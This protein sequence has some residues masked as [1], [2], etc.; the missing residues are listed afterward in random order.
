MKTN[1]HVLGDLQGATVRN[2][3]L[4]F[5]QTN[6]EDLFGDTG[7]IR[8][9]SEPVP[10]RQLSEEVALHPQP[11]ATFDND[12]QVT[13]AI[14]G[15]AEAL[16]CSSR[17]TSIPQQTTD[18]RKS[19]IVEGHHCRFCPNC[20]LEVKPSHN[21]CPNCRYRLQL[22]AK[23]ASDL[24]GWRDTT[25]VH[26]ANPQASADTSATSFLAH[27]GRLRYLEASPADVQ[28]AR[29]L[30]QRVLAIGS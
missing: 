26:A 25:S 8:Q 21:F 12:M 27:V 23:G 30:A 20:G 13:A 15:Q 29:L 11:K 14:L 19:A 5:P 7:F 10:H 17:K 9:T 3:F 24:G 18:V 4:E 2:T 6:A 28:H 22:H 16:H 1:P